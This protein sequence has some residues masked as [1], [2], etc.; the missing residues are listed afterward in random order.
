MKFFLFPCT[1]HPGTNIP[2][3]HLQDYVCTAFHDSSNHSSKGIDYP[4]S[5]F[6]YYSKLSN[7]QCCDSLSL[8]THTELKTYVEVCKFQCWYQ[9]TQ[10]EFRAL[11]KTGTLE[12]CRW[13]YKIKNNADGSI[14]R[15]KARLVPMV[16][17]KLKDGITPFINHWLILD[18]NNAFLHGNLQEDV[19]TIVPPASRL[20]HG[21]LIN[22]FIK[23]YKNLL[24]NRNQK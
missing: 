3:T 24:K 9:A 13:V 8:T 19:H 1:N 23:K 7:P 2:P 18:V 16:I 15:F 14:N 21:N 5:N 22:P 20:L 6:L 4:I 11:E 17:I 10:A 12:T